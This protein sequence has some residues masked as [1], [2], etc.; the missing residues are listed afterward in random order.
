MAEGLTDDK[1]PKPLALVLTQAMDGGC[2]FNAETAPEAYLQNKLRELHDAVEK[3]FSKEL[4]EY[5]N[6]LY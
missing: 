2:W 1:L 6:S 4:H 3:Y 5:R